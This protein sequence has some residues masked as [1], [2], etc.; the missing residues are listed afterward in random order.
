MTY[1]SFVFFAASQMSVTAEDYYAVLGVS[2]DA[3]K[4]EIKQAFVY[5]II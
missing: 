5:L 4:D 3:S 1:T 2:S